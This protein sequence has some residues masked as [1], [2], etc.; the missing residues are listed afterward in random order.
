MVEVSTLANNKVL[1]F[2]KNNDQVSAIRIFLNEG[3]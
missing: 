3:G 1:E 2:L